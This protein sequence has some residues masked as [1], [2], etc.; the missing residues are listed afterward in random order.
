[1]SESIEEEDGE[2]TE[3]DCRFNT[4]KASER[5]SKIVQK[6]KNKRQRIKEAPRNDLLDDMEFFLTKDFC[7]CR[8]KKPRKKMQNIY[9][10]RLE[11]M[12]LYEG[13]DAKKMK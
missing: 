6:S 13:L 9:F 12:A 5:T 4:Q 10:A 2:N 7:D 8:K 11:E 1:M 3:P